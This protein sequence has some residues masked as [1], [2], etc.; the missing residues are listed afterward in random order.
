[1]QV[2]S[3]TLES[4]GGGALTEI[5]AHELARVLANINDPNTSEKAKRAISISVVFKPGADRD[6]ADVELTCVSKLAPVSKVSTRLYVGKSGGKLVAVENDPRQTGLFDADRP[7]LAAVAN[8][9][10]KEGE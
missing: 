7:A 8:F 3:V 9:S 2:Q 1:M 4:I 6:L 10:F 5:F